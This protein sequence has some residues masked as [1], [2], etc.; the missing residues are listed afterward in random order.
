MNKNKTIQA[1]RS[2]QYPN[3]NTKSKPICLSKATIEIKLMR[4]LST[5]KIQKTKER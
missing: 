4:L 2:A 5:Y 1:T 3:L